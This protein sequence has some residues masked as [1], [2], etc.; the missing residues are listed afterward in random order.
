MKR[1]LL[2]AALLAATA[3][4]ERRT[5]STPADDTPEATSLTKVVLPVG[6]SHCPSG[7]ISVA[8]NGGVVEYVCN[9]SVGPTGPTGPSGLAGPTGPTGAKGDTGN[10]AVLPLILQDAPDDDRQM[11]SL[12]HSGAAGPAPY[13]LD[14]KTM[15][16]SPTAPT[17]GA[18]GGAALVV[19]QYADRFPAII[20]D[21]VRSQA[22]L[23]LRNTS[24]DAAAAGQK[25]TGDFLD[26]HGFSAASPNARVQL[27][28]LGADLTFTSRDESR[29]WRFRTTSSAPGLV[30]S[31]D[32]AG[33]ALS[34]TRQATPVFALDSDGMPQIG[35]GNTASPPACSATLRGKFWMQ[36]G[37][38]RVKDVVLICAKDALDNY[39][40]RALY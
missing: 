35:I 7:G 33:V 4:S 17:P 24:N 32:D 37:G 29:P 34:I 26:L 36:Q 20:V 5:S 10:F 27:G 6:D 2:A 23:S 30:V 11:L 31:R 1:V 9:G 18:G 39:A 38:P 8:L 25:G 3:C 14:I 28:A 19:H 12:Y 16:D 22:L 21:N 13:A 40:W 15:A